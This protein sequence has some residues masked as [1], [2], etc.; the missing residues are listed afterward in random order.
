MMDKPNI[1]TTAGKKKFA[2]G[3]RSRPAVTP[4]TP[5]L[6]A[7]WGAPADRSGAKRGNNANPSAAK[8]APAIKTPD[9]TKEGKGQ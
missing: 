8:P 7:G 2:E 9:K 4:K 1:P 5:G 3:T 6:G